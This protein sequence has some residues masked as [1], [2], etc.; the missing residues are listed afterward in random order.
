MPDLNVWTRFVDLHGKRYYPY[1]KT[2]APWLHL[3]PIPHKKG[4][5]VILYKVEMRFTYEEAPIPPDT[6]G[7]VLQDRFVA[8]TEKRE[9]AKTSIE[10]K[11]K[12]VENKRRG[13]I[14]TA[15]LY[16][17]EM[18]VTP[19]KE[20]ILSLLNKNGMN[21]NA[22]VVWELGTTTKQITIGGD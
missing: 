9:E 18:S 16:R 2:T 17:V 3:P 20:V 12:E 13:K 21:G 14:E 5:F 11:S 1:R 6:E 22:S 4:R 10:K 19:L 8:W 15:I 7:E